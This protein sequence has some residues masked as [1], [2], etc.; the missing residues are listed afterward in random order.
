[1]CWTAEHAA[2]LGRFA[3]NVN[4]CTHSRAW[5]LGLGR[6]TRGGGGARYG[7]VPV[8]LSTVS[9]KKLPLYGCGVFTFGTVMR[10][11]LVT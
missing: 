1:M 3:A 5:D 9:S 8:A 10:P 11:L 4:I 6:W 7:P 2:M